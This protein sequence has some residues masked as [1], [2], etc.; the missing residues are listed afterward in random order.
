MEKVRRYKKTPKP[1]SCLV[2]K[3]HGAGH[4]MDGEGQRDG[5]QREMKEDRCL[6][7]VHTEH[8]V[9]GEPGGGKREP[10]SQ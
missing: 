8:V 7:C 4:K 9:Y 3:Y 6:E 5:T 2:T 10:Q 1:L